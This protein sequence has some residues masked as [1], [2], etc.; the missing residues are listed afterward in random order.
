MSVG[1]VSFDADDCFGLA[2]VEAQ[3]LEGSAEPGTIR[4]ADV[5]AYLARGEGTTSIAI[6]ARWF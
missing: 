4:C 1:D 6:L 3:R 2:V 5:V